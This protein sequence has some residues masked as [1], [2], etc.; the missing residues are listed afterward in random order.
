MMLKGIV[1]AV[2]GYGSADIQKKIYDICRLKMLGLENVSHMHTS[3]KIYGV[4]Y[5]YLV[6]ATHVIWGLRC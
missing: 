3:L 4:I 1:A 5:I 6:L 2:F